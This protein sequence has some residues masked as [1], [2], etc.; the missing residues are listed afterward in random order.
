MV[1][2]VMMIGVMLVGMV[3]FNV[4]VVLVYGMSCFIGVFFYVLYGFLNVMFLLVIICW[5]IFG[6]F[7]WY[8]DCVC[9]MGIVEVDVSD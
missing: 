7:G 1:C 3:F 6:V 9:V 5:L 2:D 4:F 8:V